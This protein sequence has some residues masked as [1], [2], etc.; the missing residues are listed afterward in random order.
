MTEHILVLKRSLVRFDLANIKYVSITKYSNE[1]FNVALCSNTSYY[2]EDVN[3]NGKRINIPDDI[4][5]N[6]YALHEIEVT[7]EI[8]SVFKKSVGSELPNVK[9]L[10][11]F[12]AN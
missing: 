1:Q 8:Q 5:I 10:M 9:K 3:R 7:P 2:R 6:Q 12:N 4:S 11:L